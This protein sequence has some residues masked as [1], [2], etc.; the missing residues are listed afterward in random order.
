MHATDLATSELRPGSDVALIESLPIE[1]L[2]QARRDSQALFA[3]LG[4]WTVDAFGQVKRIVG[5]RRQRGRNAGWVVAVETS[6]LAGM[7]AVGDVR[8]AVLAM[9]TGRADCDIEWSEYVVWKI[10]YRLMEQ[11]LVLCQHLADAVC[12]ARARRY[13]HHPFEM[14]GSGPLWCR[15]DRQEARLRRL[16][17]LRR[18]IRAGLPSNVV[19]ML[20]EYLE[21]RAPRRGV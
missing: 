13:W 9:L 5:F 17:T 12:V 11:G 6:N 14:S 7:L 1:D 10:A 15:A 4:L 18:A 21:D 16:I 8:S 20:R 2:T 19:E 3:L